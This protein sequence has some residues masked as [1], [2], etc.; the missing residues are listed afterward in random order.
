MASSTSISEQKPMKTMKQFY[1]NNEMLQEGPGE[2]LYYI[3]VCRFLRMRY[4]DTQENQEQDVRLI[5]KI[6]WSTSISERKP[7]NGMLLEGPDE[8]IYYIVVCRFLK[9]RYRDM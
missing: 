8:I 3:V 9:I 5:S 2:D 4:R 6:A 1:G 7:G